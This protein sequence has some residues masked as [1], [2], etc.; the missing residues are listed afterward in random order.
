MQFVKLPDLRILIQH[1]VTT[2][3][4]PF[5]PTYFVV[6]RSIR[7]TE[8]KHYARATI[9]PYRI[10]SPVNDDV[11]IKTTTGETWFGHLLAL[12][13]VAASKDAQ[14]LETAV[15]QFYDNANGGVFHSVPHLRRSY[16]NIITAASVRRKVLLLP[17]YPRQDKGEEYFYVNTLLYVDD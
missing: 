12:I 10:E 17:D 2:N 3:A 8:P 5:N 16:N 13:G 14:I 15:V 4:I 11:E 9:T 1:A 6:Y 7:L